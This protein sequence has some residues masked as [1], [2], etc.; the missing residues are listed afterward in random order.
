[1]TSEWQ[2]VLLVMERIKALWVPYPG[3]YGGFSLSVHRD[4]LMV[5]SWSRVVGVSGQAHVIT[6]SGCVLVEEGFV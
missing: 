6:E 2:G 4:R 5:E 1:M 3:M